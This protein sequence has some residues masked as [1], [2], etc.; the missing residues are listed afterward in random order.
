MKF[1][2][3]KKVQ[4]IL[5]IGFA[6]VGPQLFS[7]SIED[8]AQLK[9]TELKGL[10]L[11][12]NRK[13]IDSYKEQ[14]TL[15][16]AEIFLKYANWDEQNVAFNTDAFKMVRNYKEHAHQLAKD[17]PDFERND[18]VKMLNESIES[19]EKINKGI[20]FRKPYQEI[21]WSKIEINNDELLYNNKPVFL[22]DYT[23]KPE[24]PEF[25]DFFG[26]LDG[27]LISPM[28]LENKE[29]KLNDKVENEL[30]N[31]PSGKAGFIFIANNKVPDW[32]AK[33]Y[34]AEFNEI[35][36][37]PF[38]A[39][40]ID[41]LGAR[42]MMSNLFKSTVP[43][44]SGK[45]YSQLGY[46]L[47]NEPR[48]A[49]YKDSDKKVYFR[50]DVSNYT[51]DKFK[52]WLKNK[53]G[54][55]ESLNAIWDTSYVDFDGVSS[56]IPMDISL[57]GTPQWYDWTTFNQDR[58]TD[59]FSYLKSE[60]VKNDTLAK[61]HLKI[62]PSI[63]TDNDPDSGIDFE[64][65]TA[66]SDFNGNDVA[67]HYNNIRAQSDWED[68]YILGWRELYLG[69][70]F[71]KSV[72]PNTINF[73]SESHLLSTSHTRDLFMNPD[74][75]RAVYWAAYTLGLNA[76][77]TWY[78]PRGVDGAFS[79]KLTNA[80]A[81]S[82]NQQ[83]RVTQE[84]QSTIIDLNTFS[85][86]I[87]A[88]QQERKPIR[89]F[90]SKTSANQ[91]ADYMDGI[92][93]IYEDLNFEGLSLGFATKNIIKRN[94][95]NAW[96]VVV[97]YK[98]EQVTQSELEA[99]QSYLNAGGRVIIDDKS[100]K[101]DEYGRPLKGLVN[102]K[103]TLLKVTGLKQIKQSALSIVEALGGMPELTVEEITE[104]NKKSCIWR[105][106]K[107]KEGKS[108]LSVIN[109]GKQDVQLKL[110]WKNTLNKAVCID[111][112]NGIEVSSEPILKPYEVYFVEVKE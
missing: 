9:M 57:M 46:M 100:F 6:F 62:M 108:V 91:K 67:A 107:T 72:N 50:A 20:I 97:I 58:V 86:D 32:T 95:N 19:A 96:D 25:E 12:L 106:V 73:N 79:R 28:Q 81:G 64:A 15:R 38:T 75:V 83:P 88:F 16:V 31:K 30:R 52:T 22:S 36:G 24:T 42:D 53:H 8:T 103:G 3:I 63:F 13:G 5:I 21:D 69:Y 34:G 76:T 33:A 47:T 23:W 2:K 7:Q 65:L 56:E 26:E 104:H 99:V 14:M 102:S 49:N 35:E 41:N 92:F 61:V 85:E 55:I 43:Q 40:D 87:T 74:Y 48:W 70:D 11:D 27:F 80:Y 59:W 37:K 109:F 101:T 1:F 44:I 105:F 77:Q 54:N 60:I 111:L 84:L 90:Y 68:D 29:G 94:N 39:Y 10:I 45:T 89:L 93:E 17:L 66:L 110:Q 82:N 78:W 51:I 71:L 18:V 98:T 4:F 112:I